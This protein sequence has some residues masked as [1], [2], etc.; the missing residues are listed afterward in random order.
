MHDLKNLFLKEIVEP[1]KN[2]EK[3]KKYKLAIPN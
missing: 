1:L 2:P 3:Y